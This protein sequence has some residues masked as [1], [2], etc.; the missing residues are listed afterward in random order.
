MFLANLYYKKEKIN[1][2]SVIKLFHDNNPTHFS[3]QMFTQAAKKIYENK[4]EY[5][6]FSPC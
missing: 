4:K 1:K 6:W 2:I 3:I 5:D